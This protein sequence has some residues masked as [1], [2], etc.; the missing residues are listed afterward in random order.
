MMTVLAV[1]LAS[2]V[3]PHSALAQARPDFSGTWKMDPLRS[4]SAAQAEPIGPVTLVIAQTPNELRVETT[5]AEGKSAV[6]YKLD[7]STVMVAA[8]TS[9]THWDGPK[10]VTDGVLS[11]NGATVTTTETRTLSADGKEMHV[12]RAVV[13]QHGYPDTLKG[14]QNYAAGKDV[15]VRVP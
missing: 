13:V 8:G 1:V 2:L 12:D 11:V 6:T 10:L 9:V 15:Y 4:E 3:V 14:T 7:G 5:R